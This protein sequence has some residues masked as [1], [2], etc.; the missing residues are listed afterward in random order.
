MPVFIWLCLL[1]VT[2]GTAPAALADD[3]RFGLSA[4]PAQLRGDNTSSDP[5]FSV[6]AG[7][8]RLFN[9]YLGI[10]LETGVLQVRGEARVENPASV[11]YGVHRFQTTILPA[12]VY[13]NFHLPFAFIRPW[14]SL[15]LG[16]ALW[17]PDENENIGFLPARKKIDWSVDPFAGLG[18]G[19]AFE[20]GAKNMLFF[21]DDID[22]VDGHYL[23]GSENGRDSAI[24]AALSIVYRFGGDEPVYRP[25][26]AVRVI[27]GDTPGQAAPAIKAP[28]VQDQSVPT[29]Q[30]GGAGVS[31]GER[32]TAPEAPQA[33]DE[34]MPAGNAPLRQESGTYRDRSIDRQSAEPS[35]NPVNETPP[36]RAGEPQNRESPRATPPQ[37]SRTFFVHVSSLPDQQ[38]A[39]ID[40]RRFAGAGYS[41]TVNRVDQGEIGIWYRVY[42]GPY[43][44]R[45]AASEAADRLVAS[46]ATGYAVVLEL[47]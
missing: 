19:I 38:A 21:R 26:P 24:Q 30:D 16:A 34:G 28:P 1:V 15:G 46:G 37:S 8:E 41:V 17:M 13:A 18:G 23:T 4:G 29:A 14:I 25:A 5:G 39:A 3:H 44:T 31:P 33:Q 45:D 43:P 42:V 35:P 32:D 36:S 7:Y 22:N 40:A 6:Q 27:P 2:F 11:F 47:P 12:G 10:G 9:P 20:I